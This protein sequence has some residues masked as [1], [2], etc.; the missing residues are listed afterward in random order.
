MVR[1]EAPVEPAAT[2]GAGSRRAF[3]I[4]R[5]VYAVAPILFGLDKFARVLQPHWEK[6]LAPWIDH[7]VPGTAHDAMLIVGAV[8]ITAGITIALYPRIGGLI[9]A[10][11]LVGIIVS[12]LSVGGYGDIVLRDVG[13]LAG[14][15]ALS[16]LAADRPRTV[17]I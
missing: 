15:L 12:L 14:A 6:Y 16:S 8:E 2:V 17:A 9:V 7:L 3:V 13:L 11:W 1:T 4:L 5:T 10:V